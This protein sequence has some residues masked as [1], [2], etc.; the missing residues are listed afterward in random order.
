MTPTTH[1]LT[2]TPNYHPSLYNP[3]AALQAEF[4]RLIHAAIISP[5]FQKQL[6]NSPALSID[7]GF[8]GESFQ[9]PAEIKSRIDLIR[10]GTLEDFSTQ[11]L[12]VT[13]SSRIQE[14][15]VINYH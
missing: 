8:C 9:I 13:T 2:S 6:L 10:A 14:S 15:A 12:Q 5:S 7:K 11:L 3:E 4:G 1:A